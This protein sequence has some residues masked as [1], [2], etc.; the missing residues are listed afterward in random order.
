MTIDETTGIISGRWNEFGQAGV[1]VTATD[2]F[3]AFDTEG[4]LLSVF[5]PQ[6]TDMFLNE[7]NAVRDTNILSG[8]DT[9]FGSIPGNGGDWFELVTVADHLDVRGWTLELS[10]KANPEGTQQ[11]TDILQFTDDPLL[12]DL[13]GGTIITVSESLAD[14]ASYD[15]VG[16]DWWINL[17]ANSADAGAYFTAESQS[18]FSV[19]SQD[20]QLI[21]RDASGRAVFGPAGEG[22]A[23]V[24][25]ISGSEVGEL[26]ERNPTPFVTPVGPYGDGTASS[27]GAPNRNPIQNF[28]ALRPVLVDTKEPDS[29]VTSPR[30]LDVLGS[31]EVTLTGNASDDFGVSEVAVAIRNRDTGQ[32]LQADGTFGS[33]D[34]LP[35]TVDRP[36]RNYTEWS[37]PVTLADGR[38][39]LS[40]RAEDTEGNRETFRPWVPFEVSAAAA[41]V[42]EPDATVTEP[43][44]LQV[45]DGPDVVL[46]GQA[47]DDVA[48]E[49]VGV[50]I[51][52][53]NTRLWL[54]PDGSFGSFNRMNA[55][56]TS[57]DSA[58]TAWSLPV[59]LPDGSY[60]MSVQAI[61]SSANRDS[62]RTWVV[63][64]VVAPAVDSD[65]PDTELT[66]P[67]PRQTFTG[68]TVAFS[69]NATDNT[70]VTR[71]A[72]SLRS[73]TTDLWLQ[74]DGSYGG[75]ALLDAT[76]DTPGSTNTG[77]TFSADLPADTYAVGVRS[78][79]AAGNVDSTRPYARFSVN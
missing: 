10:D 74:S 2:P 26:Q 45:L 67:A 38:W 44:R 13:R 58:T 49:R 27:F 11:G 18:N 55:N 34:F 57:P 73:K 54:Q 62:T 41:D 19:S 68:P 64:N 79:D 33:I 65:E 35:A 69:G 56:L 20:W 59:S 23:S 66:T 9:F 75:F 1:T 47:T 4:F 52:D 76:L 29:T 37:F 42:V 77:W 14:D 12:A 17:Q 5:Y 39:A 24:S 16:G 72:L 25:G 40:V 22:A 7:W 48:I 71:V 30:R 15:P 53:R 70:G 21:I 28:D 31:S 51:Q 78:Y 36:G 50:A 8:G 61:D 43:V 63:F 32:W 3:G 60:G 46:S 6:P